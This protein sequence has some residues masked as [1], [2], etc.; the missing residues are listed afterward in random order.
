VTTNIF[1]WSDQTWLCLDQAGILTGDVLML[2][3]IAGALWAWLKREDMRRWFSRNRF[4]DV[5]GSFDDDETDWDGI[6][7]TVSH[8]SVPEWVMKRC[9]PSMIALIATPQ[10]APASCQL[11]EI[12]ASLNIR[13]ASTRIITD[14]DDPQQA[15]RAVAAALEEMREAAL[16][17]LAV[18]VTGGKT[19]MSLGAFMAAEEAESDSMYISSRFDVDL[20]KPDMTTASIR[21]ISEA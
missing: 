1:D 3:T 8:S 4:P 12:A 5:G 14:P 16:V 13:V 9:K 18:D 17:H 2:I 11:T 19:P 15:R 21:R 6:V 7:F 10:S 20:K